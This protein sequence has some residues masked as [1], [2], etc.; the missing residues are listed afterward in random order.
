MPVLCP[1]DSKA[2]L[3]LQR[4]RSKLAELKAAGND[5]PVYAD[6]PD[7]F[8]SVL[9]SRV[10]EV[11]QRI[12]G[13]DDRLEALF[14]VYKDVALYLCEDPM[15]QTVDDF[16]R[17]MRHIAE[18]C[19]EAAKKVRLTAHAQSSESI[20]CPAPRVGSAHVYT[21]GLGTDRGREEAGK[22]AAEAQREE[23]NPHFR[24]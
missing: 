1:A 18:L 6:A 4:I 23:R 21:A 12:A 17:Q 2:C 5:V 15:K 10:S 16:L 7:S 11:E 19:K 13:L 8:H 14:A 20:R 24:E 22:A 9:Q 3:Q